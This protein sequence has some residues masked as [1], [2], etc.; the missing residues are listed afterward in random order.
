MLITTQERSVLLM[1]K[2]PV[3]SAKKTKM[4]G[5]SG[6]RTEN[7]VYHC[8]AAIWNVLASWV[9][10]ASEIGYNVVMPGTKMNSRSAH[11]VALWGEAK[12]AVALALRKAGEIGMENPSLSRDIHRVLWSENYSLRNCSSFVTP[13]ICLRLMWYSKILVISVNVQLDVCCEQHSGRSRFIM[14]S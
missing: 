3:K 12:R 13:A 14:E 10:A 4:L 7:K 11:A 9:W 2:S 1:L 6:E 5:N 8:L